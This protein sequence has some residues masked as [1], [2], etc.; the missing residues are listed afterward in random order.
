MP[1]I[2]MLGDRRVTSLASIA[3]TLNLIDHQTK[4]V[5]CP[6]REEEDRWWQKRWDSNEEI[7]VSRVESAEK[8]GTC[9]EN[10]INVVLC[11]KK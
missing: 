6:K 3:F 5:S 4:V 7:E 11:V 8:D 9:I 10:D 2:R 1:N